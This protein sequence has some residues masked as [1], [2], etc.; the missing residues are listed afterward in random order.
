[1]FTMDRLDSRGTNISKSDFLFCQKNARRSNKRSVRNCFKRQRKT[2]LAHQIYKENFPA[3]TDELD[4]NLFLYL[5]AV[6]KRDF[7]RET[8]N[9]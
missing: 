8:N 3:V 1:M 4:E 5:Y 6:C 7:M 2:L 9:C